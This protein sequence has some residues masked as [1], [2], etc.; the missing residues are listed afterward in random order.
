MGPVVLAGE[1]GGA[2]GAS[3]GTPCGGYV[4]L[5]RVAKGVRGW[6]ASFRRWPCFEGVTR[7]FLLSPGLWVIKG[8]GL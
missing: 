1:G 2:S 4:D 7:G 5:Y 6:L 8:F 3:P